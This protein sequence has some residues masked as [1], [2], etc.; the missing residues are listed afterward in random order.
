MRIA[1]VVDSLH[2]GGS[3]RQACCTARGLAMAGHDVELFYY[4]K[5]RNEYESSS[6]APAKLTL[7]TKN[8]IP[9]MFL[10]KLARR[11]R[12]GRFQVVHA[13]KDNPS[14]YACIAAWLAR[15]PVR[16]S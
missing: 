3:E 12:T 14:I 8:R 15:V 1:V 10:L 9:P 5:T 4:Y 11:F 7:L 2:R 16:I 13:F 6:V